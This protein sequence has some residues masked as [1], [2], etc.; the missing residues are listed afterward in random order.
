MQLSFGKDTNKI[1]EG[2]KVIIVEGFTEV[3]FF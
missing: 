3:L 2:D 1:K